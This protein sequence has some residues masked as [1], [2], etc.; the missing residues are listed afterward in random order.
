MTVNYKVTI[1]DMIARDFRTAALF[2]G[3]EIDLLTE[4]DKTIAIVCKDNEISLLH[5]MSDLNA[6]L[7]S[8]R[9]PPSNYSSWPMRLLSD[10]ITIRYG[11]LKDNLP[12]IQQFLNSLSEIHEGHSQCI[13]DLRTSFNACAKQLILSLQKQ[14]PITFSSIRQMISTEEDHILF[15]GS[16]FETVG[17]SI[18]KMT[19][20]LSIHKRNF[21]SVLGL[22][23]SYVPPLNAC[24]CYKISQDLLTELQNDLF[25][26]I[27][28]QN[29][30]YAKVM[31]LRNRSI[32]D[33]Q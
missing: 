23:N 31:T 17:Y 21:L 15:T 4:R 10:L 6:I 8:T 5:L 9:T 11:H 29:V 3:Y 7:T 19:D 32:M 2:L 20:E 24:G 22:I 26:I 28:L 13:I 18:K 27:G 1:G 12:V 33:C 16:A 25:K 14:A 30:L